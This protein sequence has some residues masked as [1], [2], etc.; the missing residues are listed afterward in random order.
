MSTFPMLVLMF[1]IGIWF[2]RT[3]PGGGV[4]EARK[5]P[6]TVRDGRIGG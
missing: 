2:Y 4:K 5:K 3:L 6:H 1:V